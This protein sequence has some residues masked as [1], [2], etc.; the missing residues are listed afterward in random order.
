MFLHQLRIR[1]MALLQELDART[2]QFRTV[3]GLQCPTGCGAC[4]LSDKVEATVLEL[5]PLAISL[6]GSEAGDRLIERLSQPG[7][8]AH[9]VLYDP[10]GLDGH[11]SAYA[12]RGVVCRLFAF[13]GNLD[14]DRVP[15]LAAC[16]VMRLVSPEMVSRAEALIALEPSLLPIFSEAG[17]RLSAMD[18]GLGTRRLPINEALREAMAK[19]EVMRLYTGTINMVAEETPEETLFEDGLEA[20][21]P[22]PG[23]FG[24]QTGT[25]GVQ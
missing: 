10:A 22:F 23:E 5:L 19:V 24:N 9:C 4:C 6:M 8:A 13:A 17:I 3:S 21:G 14:R 25:G 2:A 16:K 11:C 12:H 1:V 15:Q 20:H 18:P 7:L